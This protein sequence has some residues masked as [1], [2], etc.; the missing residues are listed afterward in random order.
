MGTQIASLCTYYGYNVKIYDI[1][2]PANILKQIKRNH[3]YLKRNDSSQE[4]QPGLCE[5]VDDLQDFSNVDIVIECVAEKIEVKGHVL[6]TLEQ[7]VHDDTIIGTNT[8]SFSIAELSHERLIPERFMGI[9]FFN[10]VHSISLVELC[11][12]TTS[13]PEIIESVQSF[14]ESLKRNIVNVPDIPGFIVNRLLF[15]MIAE[16]ARMLENSKLKAEDI[17]K[18]MM[19]GTGMP[20][21]PL[22]IADII[23]LDI[24]LNI[25]TQLHERT[26]S[27]VYAPPHLLTE[28][29]N[30][31]H[32][33][34]KTNNGF[35]NRG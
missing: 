28:L 23:G 3:R 1:N 5:I 25:L 15:L 9:H 17:D 29:V 11:P 32:L 8:S 7:I 33:G 27:N 13:S 31:G 6:N 2:Q 30:C 22:A 20:M 10:P 18:A 4:G 26:S 24:C 34:K 35:Y 14:L 21:G 16:S 19:S 12:N